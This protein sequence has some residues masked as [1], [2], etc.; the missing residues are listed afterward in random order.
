MKKPIPW[1][2]ILIIALCIWLAFLFVLFLAVYLP[3]ARKKYSDDLSK[4]NEAIARYSTPV[5]SSF[6]SSSSPLVEESPHTWF[7]PINGKRLQLPEG[8]SNS[9]YETLQSGGA[10]VGTF[11]TSINIDDGGGALEQVSV[12]VTG[13]KMS[14]DSFVSLL[15]RAKVKAIGKTMELSKP[16]FYKTN[17]FELAEFSGIME[18]DGLRFENVVHVWAQEQTIFWYDASS[19]P[20]ND[21]VAKR[22]SARFLNFMLENTKE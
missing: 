7:N 5:T 9:V 8:F 6:P 1:K 20:E 11:S 14:L 22:D 18:T 10:V 12:E 13:K 16:K 2:K 17:G 21:E 15:Y 19:T 3:H 4:A